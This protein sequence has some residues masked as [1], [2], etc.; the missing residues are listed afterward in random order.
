MSQE[1][2]D[3]NGET[4]GGS[5]NPFAELATPVPQNDAFGDRDQ[6]LAYFQELTHLDDIE[7]CQ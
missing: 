7:Q 6:I 3:Q 4:R 1:N 5:S 2:G